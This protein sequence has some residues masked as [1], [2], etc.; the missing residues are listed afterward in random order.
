MVEEKNLETIILAG[1]CFWCTEAIFLRL[2]GVKTVVS[3]YSGGEK[4]NPTYEEVSSGETGH[5]ECIKIEFDP[6]E[7]TLDK[8]LEVFLNL[9]DPTTLN[10]QGADTGTQY[11]S[12]IFYMDDKQKSVIDEAIKKAQVHYKDKIVTEVVKY[13]N[14]FK[15]EDYH[16]K[17]YDSNKGAMYC[18]L[19][20]TPKIKKLLDMYSGIVKADVS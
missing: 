2:K 5:A 15:A 4:E 20:I 19:V 18:N 8:I 10:R 14:F 7:I 6:T 17:Y 9:H 3:G 16:Q 13:K 12:A 11:R 1:G